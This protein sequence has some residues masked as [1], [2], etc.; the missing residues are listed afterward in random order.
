VLID[1]ELPQIALVSAGRLRP[2]EPAKDTPD[3]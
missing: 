1:P 3:A 2:R